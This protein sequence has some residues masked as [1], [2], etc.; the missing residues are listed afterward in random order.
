MRGRVAG[1]VAGTL[2]LAVAAVALG[3][4]GTTIQ[5]YD[6][7]FSQKGENK[8][9]GTSLDISSRDPDNPLNRQPKRITNFDITFPAGSRIDLKA[10]PRCRGDFRADPVAV[11]PAGARIG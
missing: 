8:S 3:G 4:A 1:G 5:R 2:S 9:T 7:S 6:H 11:C 10:A